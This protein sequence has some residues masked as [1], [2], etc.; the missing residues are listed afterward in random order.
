MFCILELQT[1]TSGTNHLTVSKR[2]LCFYSPF[3]IV[4]LPSTY[5]E[6]KKMYSME[7]E[8]FPMITEGRAKKKS[9]GQISG[10]FF[11]SCSHR[12]EK[13]KSTSNRLERVKEG[14]DGES[15]SVEY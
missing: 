1:V 15:W 9:M 4:S 3:L 12:S 11:K 2:V 7:S 6:E 10:I 8:V 13:Y 5:S 14:R